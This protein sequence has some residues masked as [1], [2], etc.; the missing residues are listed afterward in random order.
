MSNRNRFSH[1][2]SGYNIDVVP[3]EGEVDV[4]VCGLVE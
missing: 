4:E 2:Y 1:D 3:R